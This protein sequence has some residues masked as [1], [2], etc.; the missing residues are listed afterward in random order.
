MA[1]KA[2]KVMVL[3]IDAPIVPRLRKYALEGKLPALQK[4]FQEGVHAP[5]T[6]VPFPTITPPNWTTITTG[7]WPGTHGITDFEGHHPGDPLDKTFQNFDST[8]VKAERIWEAAAKVGKKT[9]LLNYPASHKANLQ[10]GLI[11]GGYGLNINDWRY[12]IS[13][14]TNQ[15]NNLSHDL[16]VTTVPYPFATEIELKK[17]DGWEGVEHSPNAK[18]ATVTLN[19]RRSLHQVE[20]WTWHLLVDDSAGKGYDTVLVAKSKKKADVIARL[21]AGEWTA[22]I[23]DTFQ[24]DQGPKKAGFRFKLLELSPDGEVLRLYVP[25][26]CSMQDWATPSSLEEE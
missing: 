10:D 19:A 15:L 6:L 12:G 17:A 21:G 23:Y 7:A 25:G 16:L 9:I 18:E 4:V 20:P 13:K 22:N 5:N 24:T 3:G 1:N 8:E 14:A 11:I 26:I 2:E